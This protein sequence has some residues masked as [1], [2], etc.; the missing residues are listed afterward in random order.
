MKKISLLFVGAMSTLPLFSATP[1]VTE[2]ISIFNVIGSLLGVVGIV[3]FA[4][5][6]ASGG[7]DLLPGKNYEHE[8]RV[9]RGDKKM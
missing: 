6:I 7:W 1:G 4:Y 3:V 2:S 9:H 5:H 8:D